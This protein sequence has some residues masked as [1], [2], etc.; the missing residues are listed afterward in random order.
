M[1]LTAIT[2]TSM[3][4]VRTP[5]ARIAAYVNQGT[6]E[7]DILVKV[8]KKSPMLKTLDFFKKKKN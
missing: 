2:V 8:R 4:I 3:Q 1:K 5:L 7:M 6:A